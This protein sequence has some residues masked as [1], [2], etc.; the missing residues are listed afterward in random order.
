M[1]T[2]EETH[3]ETTPMLSRK[4]LE[5]LKVLFGEQSN[6]QVPVAMAEQVL[7]IRHWAQ[8]NAAT[9]AISEP[10]AEP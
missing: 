5:L 3:T 7:E 4:S 9:T 6:L 8:V 1:P 10:V 2:H